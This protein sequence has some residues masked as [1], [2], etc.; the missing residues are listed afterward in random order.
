MR[1]I[2]SCCKKSVDFLQQLF[3]FLLFSL[4]FFFSI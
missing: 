4:A 2:R 1:T 3:Y